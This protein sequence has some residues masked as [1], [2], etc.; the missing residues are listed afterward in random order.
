M[1]YML[2]LKSCINLMCP[3]NLMPVSQH[4]PPLAVK[5][6]LAEEAEGPQTPVQSFSLM[7]TLP[8]PGPRVSS[9]TSDMPL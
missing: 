5:I 7:T 4:K 9:D 8:T 1:Y 2:P 3:Q 6:T